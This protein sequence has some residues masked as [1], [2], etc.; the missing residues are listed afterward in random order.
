M[1]HRSLRSTARLMW[2]VGHMSS[3]N[4]LP[5]LD[6][7]TLLESAAIHWRR[8]FD[9]LAAGF[10]LGVLFTLALQGLFG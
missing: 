9:A 10:V 3:T 8:D 1:R 4:G 6:P 2:C 7:V 5:P